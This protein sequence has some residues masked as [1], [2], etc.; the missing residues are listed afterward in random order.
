MLQATNSTTELD[1]EGTSSAARQFEHDALTEM[2][3]AGR[4]GGGRM[5]P[6]M[7]HLLVR[8]LGSLDLSLDS[9][10]VAGALPHYPETYGTA[11][12][13]ETLDNLGVRRTVGRTRGALLGDCPAAT[14]VF[15]DRALWLIDTSETQ[16]ILFRLLGDGETGQR[17]K[18]SPGRQYRTVGFEVPAHAANGPRAARQEPT[19]VADAF[20][21]VVS[22]LRLIVFMSVLSGLTAIVAVYGIMTI[23]DVVIPS[24]NLST[25]LGFAVGL[26][27][28]FALDLVIR[29]LKGSCIG[30]VSGRIECILGNALLQKLLTL[31]TSMI[32]SAPIADQ[33]ARLRQFE[34]MRDVFG[35]PIAAVVFELP[36]TLIVLGCIA[37]IAWQISLIQVGLILLFIVPALLLTPGLRR[38]SRALARKQ[39]TVTGLLLE[40]VAKRGQIGQDGVW[41]P[42]L[43]KL[44]GAVLELVRQRRCLAAYQRSMDALSQACLPASAACVIGAGALLVMSGHMTEGQLVAAV[45]LTWR[46]FAPVQQVV[47]LLPQ[48]FNTSDLFRQIDETMLLPSD[49]AQQTDVVAEV[50]S[51]RL[52][53]NN[54]VLRHPNSVLPTLFGVTLDIPH[55]SFVTVTGVSGSGKSS[56]L[57]VLAGQLAPQSGTV[58]INNLNIHRMSQGQR[59]ASIALVPEA[60]LFF[61]GTVAQNLR[62]ADPGAPDDML[63]Y[64]LDEVGLLDW[65]EGLPKGLETRLDPDRDSLVLTSQVR[66]CLALAQALLRRSAILLLDAPRSRLDAKLEESV[67]SAIDR[68]RGRVTTVMAT[69]RPAVIRRSDAVIVIESGRTRVVR[70]DDKRWAA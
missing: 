13:F 43:R 21:Q 57:S 41:A 69:H 1:P 26:V 49:A 60:P 38:E 50:S 36:F 9:R 45:I 31:P 2:L 52:T 18:I 47:G 59:A 7:A 39:N 46:L 8:L 65:L 32:S 14:L 12:L 35:G 23:F 15:L 22:E 25:V 16:P 63:L 5:A 53:A 4:I 68:R 58:R 17:R 70:P 61:Y 33:M 24:Q 37:L 6:P 20:L 42:W 56:L 55:G 29:S 30:H 51:G 10:T 3:T 28:L 64:A 11:E 66:T 27:A 44:E 19:L 62:F 67:L 34:K 48:F 40:V 54:L